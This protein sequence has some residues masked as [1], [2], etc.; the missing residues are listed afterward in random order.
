MRKEGIE[1]YTK[2]NGGAFVNLQA[3]G[4]LFQFELSYSDVEK[5]ANLYDDSL[6][7]EFNKK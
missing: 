5:W 2:G 4:Q 3:K 7:N 6:V 1:A